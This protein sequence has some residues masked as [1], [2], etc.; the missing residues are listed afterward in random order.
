MLAGDLSI[1]TPATKALIRAEVSS[2]SASTIRSKIEAA[3]PHSSPVE[4]QPPVLAGSMAP[5]QVNGFPNE[6]ASGVNRALL[7][8]TKEN[9]STRRSS[10]D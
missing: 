1:I 10:F 8:M 3:P 6:N 7:L 2:K 9:R 4:L 5:W